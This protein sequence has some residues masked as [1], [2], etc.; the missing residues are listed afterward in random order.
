MVHNLPPNL[1]DAKLRQL[2]K[3][4]AGHNAVITEVRL[5]HF[6]SLMRTEFKRERKQKNCN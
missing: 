2:F 1:D 5:L 6:T 4:H 3:N